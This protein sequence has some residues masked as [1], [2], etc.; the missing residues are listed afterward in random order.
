VKP[1]TRT[2]PVNRPHGGYA[3]AEA[4]GGT[5]P[6]CQALSQNPEDQPCQA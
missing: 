1:R 6:Q 4:P 5:L 3:A 2:M